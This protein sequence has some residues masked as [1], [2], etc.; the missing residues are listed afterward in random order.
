M[1][2]IFIVASKG[3]PAKY[4]GFETFVENLTKR[5][6]SKDIYY[7]VSCMGEPIGH[8]RYNNADCFNVKVPF[9]GAPGRI[10]HVGLVLSYVEGWVRHKGLVSNP[11][12]SDEVLSSEQ[13]SES[14]ENEVLSSEQKIE[15]ALSEKESEAGS[16]ASCEET[17][18]KKT[19]KVI[20]YI[21]G[22]RIGPLLKSH[23]KKLHK[24]GVKVFVNPDGLEWKRSK[25]SEPEKKFLKYCEKCLVENSDLSICDSKSIEK[26]INESYGTK[27]RR[28]TYIA[29]GADVERSKCFDDELDNWF[30]EHDV[31]PYEYYLIVGRFV[32]DNNYETMISEFIKSNTTKDLVIVTNVEKD[33]FYEELEEKTH[34]EEDK[35]VK[36][37][38]TVYESE[39]IKA[40]REKAFAYLHGHEVG[41]TNPSLLEALASTDVNLLYDIGFNHEVG[42]DSALYWSKEDGSLSSLIE[43]CDMEYSSEEKRKKMH[44]KGV[45]RI[46][47]AFSWNFIVDSY[48]KVFLSE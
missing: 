28:T 36:F 9:P 8:F 33:K 27:V 3:I 47:G 43:K 2:H 16:V 13:K 34:F 35:R 40:I 24:L 45:E 20:V 48:E 11:D 15:A 23:Y 6:K 17:A 1:T 12:V 32:P 14:A 4:G 30:S 18:L 10:F 26:Y 7:H 42:E 21:L 37:V 46:T 29:Y 44:E 41:G 25:W 39:L 31:K 22:C 38:G 19:D 5:K